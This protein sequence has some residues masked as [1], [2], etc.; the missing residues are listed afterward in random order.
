MTSTALE[1]Q[2]LPGENESAIL[3]AWSKGW[4]LHGRTADTLENHPVYDKATNP[5]R[6]YRESLMPENS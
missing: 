2:I 4:K 3:K 5:G 1:K 6:Q